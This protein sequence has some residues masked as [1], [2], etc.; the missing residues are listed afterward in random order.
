MSKQKENDTSGLFY[1]SNN[2]EIQDNFYLPE[3]ITK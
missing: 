3:S 1:I 2:L